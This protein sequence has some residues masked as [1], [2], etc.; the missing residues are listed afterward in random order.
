ME[1]QVEN[2]IENPIENTIEKSG[3]KS[4]V[5]DSNFHS[6]HFCSTLLEPVVHPVL[7]AFANLPLDTLVS[8]VPDPIAIGLNR[9]IR[10]GS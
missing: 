10:L 6:F 8:A 4:V 2:P 9:W 1:N 7:G 3:R 5:K